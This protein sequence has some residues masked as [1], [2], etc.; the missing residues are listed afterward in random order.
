MVSPQLL[1]LSSVLAKLG[2]S[3]PS[4]GYFMDNSNMP[5]NKQPTKYTNIECNCHSKISLQKAGSEPGDVPSAFLPE[6]SPSAPD[7]GC[8]LSVQG[9]LYLGVSLQDSPQDIA[10][11]SF[12]FLPC[13]VLLQTGHLTQREKTTK[14][15]LFFMVTKLKCFPGRFTSVFHLL[16]N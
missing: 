4:L 13:M 11:A 8:V 3:W 7:P 12:L 14:D 9:T 5:K 10:T 16:S 6:S 2:P 15:G 1:I